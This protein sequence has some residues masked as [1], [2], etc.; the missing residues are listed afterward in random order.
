MAVPYSGPVRFIARGSQSAAKKY[1]GLSRKL[2]GMSIERAGPHKVNWVRRL[3]DGAIIKVSSWSGGKEGY[4]VRITPPDIEIKEGEGALSGV[5]IEPTSDDAPDGWGLPRTDE[6]PVGTPVEIGNPDELG[7]STV[8]NNNPE[9]LSIYRN[10][11][12]GGD[13]YE[14]T[15][16][17][18]ILDWPIPNE[19]GYLTWR[20]ETRA[21][22]KP[23]HRYYCT[24]TG[25][26]IF[27]YNELLCEI[28]SDTIAGCGLQSIE[29]K[30]TYLY[31]IIYKESTQI[32]IIR[33]RYISTGYSNDLEY[34]V[35]DN[36]N[37][38]EDVSGWITLGS[39]NGYSNSQ[40]KL[41]SGAYFSSDGTKAVLTLSGDFFGIFVPIGIVEITINDLSYSFQYTIEDQGDVDN[42]DTENEDG[43]SDL[44][45]GYD[46]GTKIPTYS[47]STCNHLG[48]DYNTYFGEA[49]IDI[50]IIEGAG[51]SP[52][53]P[54][55]GN[56][57]YEFEE[58]QK[59]ENNIIIA[60]DYFGS[61]LKT[62]TRK[63]LDFSNYEW[64]VGS[65]QGESSLSF[66]EFGSCVSS[67]AFNC[68]NSSP[69]WLYDQQSGSTS[70]GRYPFW[71]RLT[72]TSEWFRKHLSLESLNIVLDYDT[73]EL[74]SEFSQ[75][76]NE[77]KY[78]DDPVGLLS[79]FKSGYNRYNSSTDTN[80]L[81]LRECYEEQYLPPGETV[82]PPDNSDSS[83]GVSL[84]PFK[85]I[86][87]IKQKFIL[88]C[89][90]RYSDS[91]VTLE[92]TEEMTEENN[93]LVLY[94]ATPTLVESHEGTILI[95]YGNV[96]LVNKTFPVKPQFSLSRDFL[97]SNKWSFGLDSIKTILQP[98]FNIKAIIDKYG[99]M[100]MEFPQ[101]V[102]ENSLID[103][104]EPIS[105]YI[106][107][108]ANLVQYT[109]YTSMGFNVFSNLGYTGGNPAF[110]KLL[111]V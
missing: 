75:S 83:G 14:G 34:D 76:N 4:D 111:L 20:A 8:I 55:F 92:Y 21:P 40:I 106:D 70:V 42:I 11:K 58:L 108:E 10:I 6:L 59:T 51:S 79:P 54:I 82:D 98:F 36:P 102:S 110:N 100:Y 61:T 25:T 26:E 1:H 46:E 45:T 81:Q 63:P 107:T 33:R 35:N 47:E 2:L 39:D 18:R 49:W 97:P 5:Y 41:L 90:L 72:D 105:W 57:Y 37:G 56:V 7:T 43:E 77:N 64:I 88:Y 85:N 68:S 67:I 87:S 15:T 16:P 31:A 24:P 94:P 80:L 22:N 38:W 13:D 12:Y 52:L 73:K 95:K 78:W 89:D 23:F 103:P 86:C 84:T 65:T 30:D 48:V 99:Y 74:I 71:Y 28:V 96:E 53:S 29:N 91:L 19:D 32:K 17:D 9:N 104:F 3:P 66:D 27:S 50:P 44:Y 62:I 109:N 69:Y 60:A 93:T 101:F